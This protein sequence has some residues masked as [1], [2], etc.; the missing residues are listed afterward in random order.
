MVGMDSG[1]PPVLFVVGR[2]AA[3]E[4]QALRVWQ[5]CGGHGRGLRAGRGPGWRG[6]QA[7]Q[8]CADRG[9]RDGVRVMPNHIGLQPY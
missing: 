1:S 2:E 5:G 8:G 7:Y 4:R 3:L 6:Q 9:L